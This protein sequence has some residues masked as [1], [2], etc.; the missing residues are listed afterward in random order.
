MARVFQEGFELG[1][2]SSRPAAGTYGEGLWMPIWNGSYIPAHHVIATAGVMNS[3]SYC[4]YANGRSIFGG[5]GS[6]MVANFGSLVEHFG[7]VELR[8]E[9]TDVDI[10]LITVLDSAYG[11]ALTI[12]NRDTNLRILLGSTL[13]GTIDGV[14]VL[15]AYTRVEWHFI[16][17]ATDGLVEVKV[18][19]NSLFTWTG[20]TRGARGATVTHVGLGVGTGVF[21]G[22]LPFGKNQN[23]YFDDV[24]INDT[25]GAIN[26]S[27]CGKGSIFL[28]KPKG[29]GHYSQFTPSNVSLDNYEL[30]D[31][32]PSDQDTT[33]VKS[34]TA[35]NVDT[36][37]MEELIA[38]HGIDPTLLVVKAVQV[39]FT[40]R[41]EGVD[42]HLAPMLRHGTTDAEGAP[43]ELLTTYHKLRHQVFNV[44]PFTGLAWTY[45]E[46]D[47]LEA[48]VK[49]KEHT[50][51]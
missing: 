30:V 34:E 18:N 20:D 32:V 25:S 10:A 4:M 9:F 5:V 23:V 51:G 24:A 37:N 12:G 29:V 41:Y 33:Y 46:V 1:R 8:T 45:A 11:R 19:G 27:W 17:D 35:E 22:N 43:I 40:G 28:L 15:G 31:E 44:S 26:N 49:H 39:C 7:R 47:A 3:G 50:H 21:T 48:G 36:Y 38:D 6:L 14:V 2:P 42:A 16:V 13:I